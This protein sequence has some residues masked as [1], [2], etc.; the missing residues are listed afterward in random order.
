MPPVE[1]A[2]LLETSDVHPLLTPVVKSKPETLTPIQHQPTLPPPQASPKIKPPPGTGSQ[3]LKQSSLPLWQMFGS[4]LNT[5]AV[6]ANMVTG[7]ESLDLDVLA[8]AAVSKRK[9]QVQIGST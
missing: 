6:M 1:Y 2:P 8:K 3:S 4:T 9:E 7:G 5:P